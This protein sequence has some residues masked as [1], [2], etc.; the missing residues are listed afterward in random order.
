MDSRVLRLIF[1][2]IDLDLQPDSL[3]DIAYI[4]SGHKWVNCFPAEN[5][6]G[7]FFTYTTSPFPIIK[8]KRE[9]ET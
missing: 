7:F 1:Y 3:H 9:A 6:F 5:L 2:L 4:L 8:T